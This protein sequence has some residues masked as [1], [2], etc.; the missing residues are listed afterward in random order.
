M[1]LAAGAEYG[2]L[3]LARLRRVASD[4][5]TQRG[6]DALLAAILLVASLA[7][8]AAGAEEWSGPVALEFFLAVV[9]AVPLAWRRSH[10][11]V[12]VAVVAAATTAAAAVVAPAQGPFEPFIAFEL[13]VYSVGVHCRRREGVIAL[14]VVVIAGAATWAVV[15]ETVDGAHYGD[16]LPALVYAV[17]VWLVGRV[18][19][20][21]NER[22]QELERLALELANER[23]ARAREA[24]TVERARIA[25]E[26]HDIVAHNITVMGIQATAASR[27]I[28]GDQPHVREALS[29]IE[30]TSRETVDEMRH[31]LGV[32]R[33][34]DDEIGLAPQPSLRDLDTL[35]EQVR[36]AG[37][38]VDVRV[39]GE[40]RPLPAGL[41]LSAYRIVQEALTNALK[42]AAPAHV[43]VAV[44]YL[45]D[46]IVLVVVDDGTR[47]VP[48]R[49]TG[50]GLVGMR[51]RAALFGGDLHAGR[52]AGGGWELHVTLPVGAA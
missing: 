44:R 2:A 4:P 1:A 23:D 16:W 24:V 31:M 48:G 41:D 14:T 13:A 25:R 10:P 51:E 19:R 5:R 52:R 12:V 21:R 50:N 18:I 46:R 34:D 37:L 20:S 38:D 32:L 29:V 39:E 42:H 40:P 33:R 8:I 28:E 11:L 15:A 26:L 35:V 30:T 45:D 47:T 43:D 17:L 27:I 49:G 36:H 3:V 7:E 22:T 9:C 6:S